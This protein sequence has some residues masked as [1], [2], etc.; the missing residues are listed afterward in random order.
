MAIT[1]ICA[2]FAHYCGIHY[3]SKTMVPS[4]TC[5]A[6]PEIK[7]RSLFGER[8]DTFR[9][10]EHRYRRPYVVCGDFV[11][12]NS[13]SV[14]VLALKNAI[15]HLVILTV[16]R[17]RQPCSESKPFR[18]IVSSIT[19]AGLRERRPMMTLTVTIGYPAPINPR[20]SSEPQISSSPHP[21]IPP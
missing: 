3:S 13:S 9:E 14:V 5:R 1:C 7:R 8:R 18:R 6:F 20:P 21:T 10:C 15:F 4:P 19:D 11:L 16:A 12:H 17:P 2:T